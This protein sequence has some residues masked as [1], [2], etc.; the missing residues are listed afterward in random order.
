VIKG[1]GMPKHLYPDERGD[2]FV[3]YQLVL[4]TALTPEQQKS[5]NDILE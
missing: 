1:Y 5:I 2:L 4:P 3:T